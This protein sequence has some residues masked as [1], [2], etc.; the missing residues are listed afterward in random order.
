MAL[1]PLPVLNDPSPDELRER[2]EAAI[3][4]SRVTEADGDGHHFRVT[5][6]SDSF[7][8]VSRINRHRTI[9]EIFEGELGGRI[10]AHSIS[11]Q[12][13]EEAK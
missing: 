4:D 13:S 2:I 9:N 8:G 5:V 11:C 1:D 7:E 12:T 6:I 3:P 10:H